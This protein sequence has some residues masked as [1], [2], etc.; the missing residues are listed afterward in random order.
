MLY[1]IL[2]K[3]LFSLKIANKL[4]IREPT[5]SRSYHTVHI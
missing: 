2:Y 1:K 4:V 3:M 5:Q